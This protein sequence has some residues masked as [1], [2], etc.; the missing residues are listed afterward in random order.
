MIN[1]GIE[2][3][4]SGIRVVKSFA[5]EDVELEKFKENNAQF[6]QREATVIVTYL[7][8]TAVSVR[9]VHSFMLP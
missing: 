2:D 6:V 7:N 4:I 8:I 9:L 5:N 3:S 1:A